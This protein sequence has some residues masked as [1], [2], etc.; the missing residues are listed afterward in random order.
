MLSLS[1]KG[2]FLKSAM[3]VHLKYALTTKLISIHNNQEIN[4]ASAFIAS[5]CIFVFI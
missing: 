2:I 3:S 1:R 4:D 5:P